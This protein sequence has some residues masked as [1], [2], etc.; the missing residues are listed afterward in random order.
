VAYFKELSEDLP[1]EILEKTCNAR[2]DGIQVDYRTSE[3]R[4]R[5]LLQ[6]PSARGMHSI[7][8]TVS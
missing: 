6:L 4:S 3:Y 7:N 8:E 5:K 1:R 2:I